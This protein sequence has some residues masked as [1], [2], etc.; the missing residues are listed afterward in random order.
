MDI[1]GYYQVSYL[2]FERKIFTINYTFPRNDLP[3][4]IKELYAN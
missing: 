4:A 2:S 3:L 1:M